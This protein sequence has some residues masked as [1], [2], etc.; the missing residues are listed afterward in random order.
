M[1]IRMVLLVTAAICETQRRGRVISAMLV[2]NDRRSR[3]APIRPKT[4]DRQRARDINSDLRQEEPLFLQKM[5]KESAISSTNV[6]NMGI[7][8]KRLSPAL[9]RA[10][11]DVAPSIISR[12]YKEHRTYTHKL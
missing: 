2:G 3:Q 12:S 9:M 1:A 8:S 6:I 11:L 10:S 7:R 4:F 5:R